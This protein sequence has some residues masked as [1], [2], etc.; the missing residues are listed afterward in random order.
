VSIRGSKNQK[1]PNFPAAI[2]TALCYNTP[3][4]NKGQKGEKGGEQFSDQSA[5]ISEPISV[6]FRATCLAEAFGEGGFRGKGINL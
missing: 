5:V 4:V 3:T 1:N 6:L 2:K